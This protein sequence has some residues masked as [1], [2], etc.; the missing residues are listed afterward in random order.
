[1]AVCDWLVHVLLFYAKMVAEEANSK[2]NVRKKR[3]LQ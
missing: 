1:M 2:Q 3:N